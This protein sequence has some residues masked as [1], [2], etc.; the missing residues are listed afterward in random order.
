MLHTSISG[1]RDVEW[2]MYKY[3]CL[4]LYGIRLL[5]VNGKETSSGNDFTMTNSSS[6]FY[7]YK[8]VNKVKKSH[9]YLT[10][11]YRSRI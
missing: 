6:M 1:S 2:N 5:R 11:V 9:I 4:S 10:Y 3:I 7:F 8:Y